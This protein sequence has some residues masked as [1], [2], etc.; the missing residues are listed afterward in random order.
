MTYERS[1]PDSKDD[2]LMTLYR[3]VLVETPVARYFATYFR[4]EIQDAPS[5]GIGQAY[6]E[7]EF[8]V[9]TER[10]QKLCLEDFHDYTQTLGGETAVYMDQLLGWE[11]DTRA[12]RITMRSFGTALNDAN[13]RDSDRKSLFCNFGQFYP[14][15]TWGIAG[16]ETSFARITDNESLEKCLGS[17]YQKPY[18]DLWA[19]A[20][21][22]GDMKGFHERFE[23]ALDVHEISLMTRAFDSQSHFA[24]FYAWFRL[25]QFELR[26]IKWIL[27]CI[28][29]NITDPRRKNRWLPITFEIETSRGRGI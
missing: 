3:T 20:Q 28:T 11:A 26:N 1:G 12:L 2:G 13:A 6:E 24:C 7:E 25:K 21:T 17:F 5:G 29:Q 16:S 19:S 8:E 10:M 23:K 14:N 9:I 22:G 4:R 15:G 27:E 18:Y